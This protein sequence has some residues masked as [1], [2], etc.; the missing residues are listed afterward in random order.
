MD[1]N[2]KWYTYYDE[3]FHDR[4]ITNKKENLNIYQ[5]NLNDLFISFFLI[6]DDNNNKMLENKYIEWEKHTCEELKLIPNIELKGTTLI[7]GK[8]QYKYGLNTFFQKSIERYTYL[9]EI[10]NSSNCKYQVNIYSKTEYLINTIF[11]KVYIPQDVNINNFYYSL[12]KYLNI[13]RDRRIINSFFVSDDP[14]KPLREYSRSIKALLP[15]IK[16]IKRTKRE[17]NALNQMLKILDKTVLENK[18]LNSG[19]VKWDYSIQIDGYNKLI[20]NLDITKKDIS[21]YPDNGSGLIPYINKNEFNEV[22]EIDSKD[23]WGVRLSDILSNFIGRLISAMQ[24]EQFIDPLKD[25]E[26]Y[27]FEKRKILS[28]DWFILDKDKFELYKLISIFFNTSK[29]VYWSSHTGV[30][31]DNVVMFFSFIHYI[32]SI[33]EN[34]IEFEEYTCSEHKE[35][36]DSFSMNILKGKLDEV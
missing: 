4:K 5:G 32:G 28:E 9:F 15:K 12:I 23:C 22:K 6:L 30:Y 31:F 3:T 11:D 26:T 29:E 20:K 13:Y 10:L 35:R 24:D 17:Y 36:Y 19:K 18:N 21:F 16:N 14:Q 27:N 1:S 25:I 34:Y 7:K 8:R 2:I 33:H